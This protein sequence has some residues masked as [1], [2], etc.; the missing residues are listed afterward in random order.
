MTSCAGGAASVNAS[1]CVIDDVGDDTT[2]CSGGNMVDC[3]NEAG[4]GGDSGR[5]VADKRTSVNCKR[6]HQ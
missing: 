3:A 1:T 5:D 6:A 2:V 4:A